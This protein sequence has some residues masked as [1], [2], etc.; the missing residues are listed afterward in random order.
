[1]TDYLV[2]EEVNGE[3]TLLGKLVFNSKRIISYNERQNELSEE[4]SGINQLQQEINDLEKLTTSPL[5]IQKKYW[6]EAEVRIDS[7]K[8]E[9]LRLLENWSATS[10]LPIQE[11]NDSLPLEINGKADLK[12]I[13]T[14]TAN[15][16]SPDDYSNYAS[17][18][19]LTITDLVK[20][21]IN[22]TRI[23]LENANNELISLETYRKTREEIV[24]TEIHRNLSNDDQGIEEGGLIDRITEKR[25]RMNNLLQKQRELIAITTELE[26][27]A[28]ERMELLIHF[29][30]IW[31]EI[32]SAR[33]DIVAIIDSESASNIKAE[34]IENADREQYQ[35]LLNNIAEGLTSATNRIHNKE[36]QL[37]II[38]ANT[39]PDQLINIVKEGNANHLIKLAPEV[40]PNTSRIILSIGP[41]DIHRLEQCIL[42]DKFVIS[43]KKEGEIEFT[44][45]DSGLS[46]GE[47]ALALISVAMVSKKLP[48]V[49]DQPEDELGPAL[50]THELVEQIRNVK[51]VRQL[52]FVTHVPNIPVLADSEQIVYI[53][54]E[55]TPS[56]KASVIKCS[57]SLDQNDIVAHLLE[58]DGGDIAF[59]KRSDRYSAVIRASKEN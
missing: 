53:E 2:L 56:G 10:M 5:F 8:G 34:L 36:A 38:V 23:A 19:Y 14:F 3:A 58:L 45:I 12:K 22:N 9:L 17:R 33:R 32:R 27:F 48:L 20:Q 37:E 41:V 50:I 55:F 43:Y 4:I 59:L 21:N 52:I 57:G 42:G 26:N 47:Q 6:S 7:Y 25:R 51:S 39:T 24:D 28:K 49:I 1:M 15:T 46:G 40:T 16:A 44:S 13:G 35:L 29:H 18:I 11:S 30:T 31:E 54:Q